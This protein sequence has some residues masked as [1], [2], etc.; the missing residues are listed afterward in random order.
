MAS[1]SPMS[2]AS[3][4]SKILVDINCYIDQDLG[5]LRLISRDYHN[6]NIFNLDK[7]DQDPIDI[8]KTLYYRKDLNPLVP[9]AKDSVDIEVLDEYYSQFKERKVVDILKLS[10]STDFKSFLE[11]LKMESVVDIT[12]LCNT[13]IEEAF[14]RSKKELSQYNI[15]NA[16]DIEDVR[17]YFQ[18]YFKYTTSIK[19]KY[20]Y[21]CRTYYFSTHRLNFDDNGII[22]IPIIDKINKSS[23]QISIIDLYNVEVLDHSITKIDNEENV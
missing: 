2:A 12:I 20:I 1:L 21:A 13:D 19:E 6:D 22:N 11:M 8:I 15:I 18:L 17:D 14:A 16:K 23:S 7:L 5:L 3:L 4:R 9:F 10:T